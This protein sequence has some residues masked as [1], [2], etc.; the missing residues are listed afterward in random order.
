MV[1]KEEA[2]EP[3]GHKPSV[4][5]FNAL[6]YCVQ[7]LGNDVKQ[8]KRQMPSQQLAKQH[9]DKQSVIQICKWRG[10]L[11]SAAAPLVHPV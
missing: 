11:A 5:L 7:R 2:S 8:L 9:W 6:I 4:T 3:Y 1:P 10:S